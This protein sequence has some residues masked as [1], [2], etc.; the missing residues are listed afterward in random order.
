MLI[1]KDRMNY[2]MQKVHCLC[3]IYFGSSLVITTAKRLATAANEEMTAM[4]INHFMI[5]DL[6]T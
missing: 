3:V 6:V 2:R 4:H 1:S 5:I